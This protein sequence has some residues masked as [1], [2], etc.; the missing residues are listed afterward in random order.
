M[1]QLSMNA[2]T[3][4]FGPMMC[5]AALIYDFKGGTEL[6]C[7]SNTPFLALSSVGCQHT[8]FL[9]CVITLMCKKN[10]NS[11]FKRS[12]CGEL[13]KKKNEFRGTR[14]FSSLKLVS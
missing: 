14:K 1:V 9:V 11:D 12:Y 3:S 6:V 13:K 2:R 10:E 4:I 7:S 8:H 5:M